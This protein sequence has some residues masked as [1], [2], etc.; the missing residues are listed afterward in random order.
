LKKLH[1]HAAIALI[2]NF[3]IDKVSGWKIGYKRVYLTYSWPYPFLFSN[4]NIIGT[5]NN[6][7]LLKCAINICMGS[8]SIFW[9]SNNLRSDLLLFLFPFFT[10][11]SQNILNFFLPS[12]VSFCWYMH[13]KVFFF[14]P[15]S[16]QFIKI[17]F[18]QKKI[19]FLSS[20]FWLGWWKIFNYP[21]VPICI[22]ICLILSI[23]KWI[24]NFRIHHFFLLLNK[25]AL[26][27]I[28]FVLWFFLFY[29]A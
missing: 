9:F 4:E 18:I 22:S 5:K 24:F 21:V 8:C 26:W 20:L 16:I 7:V 13:I 10:L 2:N 11:Q 28:F 25:W 1:A 14:L 19:P 3:E 12:A 6:K 17:L 27:I 29:F 15:F 23:Q